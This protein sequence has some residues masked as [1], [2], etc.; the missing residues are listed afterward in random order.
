MQQHIEQAL[1]NLNSLNPEKGGRIKKVLRRYMD[2]EIGLNE[3]NYELRDNDLIPMP[4][5]CEMFGKANN[6]PE[7]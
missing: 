2:I 5:R 1:V 4:S 3:V 7:E 6:T